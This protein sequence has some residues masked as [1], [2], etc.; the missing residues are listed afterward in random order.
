MRLFSGS[1]ISVI[2]ASVSN[3]TLATDTAFSSATRTTLVGI[4]DSSLNQIGIFIACG[5]EAEATLTFKH[6]GDDYTAINRRIIS[7]LAGGGC[8]RPL[9]DLDPG[10]L[11]TFG[12]FL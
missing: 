7:D 1:S 8:E 6:L 10:A 3:N 2:V 12:N 4:D 5:I 11:V 9:Q